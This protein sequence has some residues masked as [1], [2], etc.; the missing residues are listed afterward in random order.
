MAAKSAAIVWVRDK[1]IEYG[2]PKRTQSAQSGHL[3][4]FGPLAAKKKRFGRLVK[5]V[6]LSVISIWLS[7]D[8]KMKREVVLA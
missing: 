6:N 5:P 8:S 4:L 7:S 3:H 2:L 1:A